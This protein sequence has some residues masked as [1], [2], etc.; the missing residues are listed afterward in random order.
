MLAI[1]EQNVEFNPSMMMMDEVEVRGALGYEDGCFEAVID[2][3]ALGA[4]P[5]AG[6]VEHISWSGL[7]DEGFGPLRR[8][9]RM[10]VMVDLPGSN[11]AS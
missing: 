2:L 11:A 6:W 1:Y 10:K 9:E 8:G 7:I 3:M 4:Y 5:T